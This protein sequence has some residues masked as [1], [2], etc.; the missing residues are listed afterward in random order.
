MGNP[1][2]QSLVFGHNT[3]V[4]DLLVPKVRVQYEATLIFRV[5][6]QLWRLKSVLQ[7]IVQDV[8]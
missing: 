7:R 2:R 1:L 5:L 6:Q 4:K 3:N 8:P